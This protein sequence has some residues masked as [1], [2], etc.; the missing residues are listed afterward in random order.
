MWA[1]RSSYISKLIDPLLF[2]AMDVVAKHHDSDESR[3]LNGFSSRT[4]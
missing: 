3:G 1:A 4:R 2:A